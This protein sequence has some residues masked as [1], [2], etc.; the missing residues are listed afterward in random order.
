[1]ANEREDYG[2]HVAAAGI[3][4]HRADRLAHTVQHLPLL[5]SVA[6]PSGNG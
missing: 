3:S 5:L 1:L 6:P 2:Q 4:F